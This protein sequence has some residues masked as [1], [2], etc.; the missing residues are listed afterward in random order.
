[1]SAGSDPSKELEEFGISTVGKD[2]IKE[3]S[4]GGG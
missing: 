4:M 1:V 2:K 3:L